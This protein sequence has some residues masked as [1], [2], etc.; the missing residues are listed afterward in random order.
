MEQYQSH[1]LC[2]RNGELKSQTTGG[3]LTIYGTA[4]FITPSF[5]MCCLILILYIYPGHYFTRVF[6]HTSEFLLP[7]LYHLFLYI[8]VPQ[9]RG[10]IP[11]LTN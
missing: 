10:I 7:V 11:P 5:F 4:G 8:F 6:K 3:H 2:R 9:G 1:D